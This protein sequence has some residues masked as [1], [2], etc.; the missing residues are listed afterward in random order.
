MKTLGEIASYVGGQL[1]GDAS[2]PIKRL[3][4]PAMVEED[5][6]LALVLS[7]SAVSILASGKISNAIL[8][9][10]VD[11]RLTPNQIV[12][13]RPRL[14][15]ARLLELF[16][17]PVHLVPGVHPN[18]VIDPS[19]TIGQNVSIGPFCWVGPE[20]KIA[21]HCRLVAHVS[22]GAG[23]AVGEH[24][25]LHAGVRI[26]D[27]CQ[28]GNRV[29]LQANVA[30]GGDGFSFGPPEPGSVESALAT[31]EIRT[32]NNE[33]VRIN[34]IGNVVIEDD[35]EIGAGSCVD[36]GT[37]GETRIGRGSKLDNLVQIGH[38]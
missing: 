23:V 36:R 37:L 14:V 24:T 8:P 3:V 35:V 38:N 16:E 25:L 32:F 6:D 21:D 22:I 31:G 13:Q 30:I 4:H 1:I 12:A 27:R 7:P 19:A 34:S 11:E 9:A 28:I 15:L 18:A 17:R 33:L 10:P 26:G 20:S 29:I 5:T 2:V